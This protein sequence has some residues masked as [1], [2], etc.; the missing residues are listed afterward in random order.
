MAGRIHIP[1]L[2]KIVKI[3]TGRKDMKT[4]NDAIA[5]L[6]FMLKWHGFK[7]NWDHVKLPIEKEKSIPL[8]IGTKKG[9]KRFDVAY[10]AANGDIILLDVVVLK[11][12]Q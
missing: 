7:V 4:H 11:A 3:E 12:K 2:D 9:R 1:Q 5:F 10:K 8:T 6:V